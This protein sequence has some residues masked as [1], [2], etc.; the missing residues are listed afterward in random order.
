MTGVQT[1][2]LPIYGA[3]AAVLNSVLDAKLIW[4]VSVEILVEYEATLYRPKFLAI[5]RWKIAAASALAASG[6]M[7]RVTVRLTHS[8]HEPDNRFYE[9]AFAASADYLVT[10]NRKHFKKDLPPTKIVNAREL[11]NRL[12]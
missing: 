2:A 9:C 6:R 7:T 4:C 10:G 3:E 12:E 8:S 11:L 5:E 1:C